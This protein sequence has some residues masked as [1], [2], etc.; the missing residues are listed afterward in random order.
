MADGVQRMDDATHGGQAVRQLGRSRYPIGD[1][2][3]DDLL[4][5]TRQPLGHRRFGRE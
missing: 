3:G 2:R 1:V 5:G 4:P